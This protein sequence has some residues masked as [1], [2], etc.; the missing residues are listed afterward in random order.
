MGCKTRVLECGWKREGGIQRHCDVMYHSANSN[1]KLGAKIM[2]HSYI[3]KSVWKAAVFFPN[4]TGKK[5]HCFYFL[6]WHMLYSRKHWRA[7]S[8]ENRWRKYPHTPFSLVLVCD[9][10]YYSRN[11]LFYILKRGFLPSRIILIW[12]ACFVSDDI[13]VSEHAEWQRSTVT[14]LLSEGEE[15][16]LCLYPKPVTCCRFSPTVA[17]FLRL[18]WQRLCQSLK[19]IWGFA[20]W[21]AIPGPPIMTANQSILY[22][23]E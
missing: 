6:S 20:G 19:Y 3:F 7:P 1:G 2:V 8:N 21:R 11:G 17:G 13:Y 10:S 12:H 9:A 16:H 14:W 4:R 23:T 22:G 15:K 5:Y 18:A